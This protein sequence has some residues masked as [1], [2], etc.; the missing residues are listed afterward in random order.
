MWNHLTDDDKFMIAY[1]KHQMWKIY[2]IRCLVSLLISLNLMRWWVVSTNPQQRPPLPFFFFF[3]VILKH[4]RK[5]KLLHKT[6]FPCL[7]IHVAVVLIM[8][9]TKSPVLLCVDY[10]LLN[11][12]GGGSWGEGGW[13]GW[14]KSWWLE[15]SLQKYKHSLKLISSSHLHFPAPIPIILCY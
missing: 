1:Q 2:S 3:T 4:F 14:R 9:L 7:I 11:G 5:G 13:R 12:G 8:C 10:G 6:H 15:T